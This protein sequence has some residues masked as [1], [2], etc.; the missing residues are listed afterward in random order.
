MHGFSA[1]QLT[2]I[3][4]LQR[5]MVLPCRKGQDHYASISC[6]LFALVLYYNRH[7]RFWRRCGDKSVPNKTVK[8]RTV[9]FDAVMVLNHL[10]YYSWSPLVPI[11]PNVMCLSFSQG[12]P[13]PYLT[14]LPAPHNS[15]IWYTGST[16]GPCRPFL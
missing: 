11:Q 4:L 9:G 13:K 3:N 7:V 15:P 10:T 14:T 1:M 6:L 5:T 16:M 2:S 12:F 8:H